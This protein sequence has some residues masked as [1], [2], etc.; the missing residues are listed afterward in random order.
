MRAGC[1]R[2][3]TTFVFAAAAGGA[4]GWGR[5]LPVG[6]AE[7]TN[8]GSANAPVNALCPTHPSMLSAPSATARLPAG[9]VVVLQIFELLFEFLERLKEWFPAN[10]DPDD[11]DVFDDQRCTHH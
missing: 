3:G 4:T 7:I 5:V 8:D 11:P 9:S 2:S 10:E 6:L 1:A